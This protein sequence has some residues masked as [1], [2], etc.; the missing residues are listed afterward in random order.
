MSSLFTKIIRREIPARIEYEDE[1]VIVI[2][3]IAPQ[4]KQHLLIIPKKEI[5]S[6]E[7]LTPDDAEVF[8]HM[9]FI[10]QIVARKL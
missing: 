7:H 5:E 10:A 1:S 6:I 4:A 8:S 9:A 3:D 2:H